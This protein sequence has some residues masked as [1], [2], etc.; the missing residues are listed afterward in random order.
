MNRKK[1]KNGISF[2]LFLIIFGFVAVRFGNSFSND[3]KVESWSEEVVELA[4]Q[5]CVNCGTLIE[6]QVPVELGYEIIEMDE[7][8]I[9][10]ANYMDEDSPEVLG[11]LS[12]VRNFLNLFS[13]GDCNI[14]DDMTL[15]SAVAL[16]ESSSGG[17]VQLSGGSAVPS[18]GGFLVDSKTRVVIT[19]VNYPLAYFLGQYV[20]ENSRREI[21]YRSP[22]YSAN[23]EN[24]DID[25]IAKTLSPQEAEEFRE[26][27]DEFILE[28]SRQ[29]FSIKAVLE[30]F[31]N[32][33]KG[34]MEA[35]IGIEE[36]DAEGECDEF[37]RYDFNNETANYVSYHERFGG[38]FR[39]QAPGGDNYEYPDDL[40]CYEEGT[41]YFMSPGGNVLSCLNFQERVRGIIQKWFGSDDWEECTEGRE[42]C[43]EITLPNG[44]TARH[45]ERIRNPQ[46]CVDTTNIGIEMAPLFGNPYHCNEPVTREV[47]S[48]EYFQG[49]Q[50][51]ELVCETIEETDRLCANAFLANSYKASLS[52]AQ[53]ASKRVGGD[54]E[55]SLMYFIGTPCK[56]NLV[57][58]NGT[59][60]PIDITC[61][62]DAS[63]NLL[64]YRLQAKDRAPG[65]EDFPQTF[66]EYWNG[67]MNAI[68]VSSEKYPL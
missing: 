26:D 63:P 60:M 35:L 9:N 52:P 28:N 65:Q 51:R 54:P 22:E 66:R 5:E 4:E 42:E 27:V 37:V 49:G 29:A 36:T 32:V 56:L 15:E 10:I 14:E 44:G 8:L 53:S 39:Q 17:T 20:H 13:S 40:A 67:V 57:S 58:E 46:K 47:C 62:W 16:C 55:Q 25:Y 6:E 23:G 3:M 7:G 12:G 45:C 59:I 24:I 1:N 38:F 50:I 34:V 2:L 64:N 19:E 61:L 18:G 31:A 21:S 48:Y 33:Q 30:L 68:E 43:W 41:H 11:L